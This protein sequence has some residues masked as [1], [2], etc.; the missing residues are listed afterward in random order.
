MVLALLLAAVL[1]F[2][3]FRGVDWSE[4]FRLIGK[5]H[6]AMVALV[7]VGFSCSYFCRGLRWSVLLRAGGAVPIPTVFWATAAGYLGNSFL[8]AR[9]GE[10]I[11]SAMLSR[12]AGM[13]VGYVLATALTERVLDAAALVVI[14]LAALATLPDLPT[15]LAATTRAMAVV[16]L[17]GLSLLLLAPRLENLILGI[18]ARLPFLTS[19]KAK[20][21]DL[22]SRFL[23]GLRAIQNPS[24]AVRFGGL[25]VVIW[26]L[27]ASST[28]VMG[29]ALDLPIDFALAFLLIAALGLSSAAPSTPG[30]VGIYQ[31]VAVSLL[32]PFG[33]NQN[34]ALAFILLFQG[35]TYAVVIAWGLPALW[36]LSVARGQPA[37][38]PAG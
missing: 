16:G 2:L 22:T 35:V 25:T 8:P 27:D 20:L 1:L 10:F 31:F 21:L 18:L 29:R 32:V 38:G 11:R 19:R 12:A 37:S 3:A 30:F 36:R 9:A 23:L 13:D 24:R 5:A 34:A 15:W 28:V 4:L 17:L 14:G 7:F 6:P 26:T 33:I